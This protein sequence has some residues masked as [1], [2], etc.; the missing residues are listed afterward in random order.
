MKKKIEDFSLLKFQKIM[1]GLVVL[2]IPIT[3]FK[4]I[5]AVFGAGS[6][7]PF[8]LFPLAILILIFAVQLFKTRKLELPKNTSTLAAFV[9][10]ALIATL[11]GLLYDP[12][13]LRGQT[14]AGRAL[15]AWSSLAIGMAFF[16][17]AYWMNKNSDDIKYTLK[18]MY[19]GLGASI[20]WGGIQIVA[21][22]F[23]FL[24]LNLI[25]K[26]QRLFSQRGIPA[27]GRI[28]G[29]AYEPSWFADQIVL[30]YYPWLVAA[31]ITGYR[32]YKNRWIEPLLLL[33]GS[34]MLVFTFSRGGIL[35]GITAV[36]ATLLITGRNQILKIWRW[37]LS[38]LR[39]SSSKKPV[40]H[41]SII[42]VI[43]IV[44]VIAIVFST[45][46]VL[47]QNKYF[48]SILDFGSATNIY[49]YVINASAGPRL[50]YAISGLN[51]YAEYP[52]T[53]VGLGASALYLYDY[54]PDWALNDL[55]EINR[56]LSPD[57]KVV[58]NVKNLYVRLLAETGIIGFWFYAA[59]YLSILAEV[60]QLYNSNK[61]ITHFV[62]IA[63]LFMW[64]AVAMRNFTQDS[65]T[66]PIMWIGFG[67][68][69]GISSKNNS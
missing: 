14:S 31:M 35:I 5:P 48:A 50:A 4:Y 13:V 28:V 33:F 61:Q 2:T 65:L 49:R 7:K 15:R 37:L 57:S 36:V 56:R 6:V 17:S 1:W 9:L 66:F 64:F 69:L 24:D 43:L 55:N 63:G 32:V 11:I 30:F 23:S 25:E 29:F 3:S 16:L 47:T 62:A 59:F 26:I 41:S 12:L 54:L 22:E 39:N 67:T 42:R 21:N 45:G 46:A 38:P 34:A 8:A 10:V 19:V 27:N 68:V 18:Y 44:V 53:G 58:S 60:R 52:W 51:V 40:A 20:I